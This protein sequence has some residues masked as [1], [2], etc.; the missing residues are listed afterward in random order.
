[1]RVKI[2]FVG[3]LLACL[4]VC[5]SCRQKQASVEE[6]DGSMWQIDLSK[7]K[8]SLRD[9]VEKI[10]F[11]P[12]EMT[13]RSVLFGADKMVLKNGLM[14]VGDFRSGK[15][16]AFDGDGKVEFVVDRKGSGP[17]EYLE[18]KSFAVDDR[19]IYAIDNYQHHLNLFDCRTGE[20]QSTKDMPLV[21]WDVEVLPDKNL[22]FAYI[23]FKEGAP[24]MPQARFKIHITDS[25]LNVE[26]QMFAY[27]ESDYECMG[28][29]TYFVPVTQGVVFSSMASDE[30]YEFCG[31]DSV[32]QM[33]LDFAHKIPA[34]HRKDLE[35]IQQRGYSYLVNTPL[36]CKQY[37]FFSSP[38][39]GM[40]L[41]YV[42]NMQTRQLYTNDLEDAYKG[43]LTP[44]VVDGGRVIAYFDNY[45][46][47]QD[48]VQAGFERAPRAVEEHL[49]AEKPVL[50][51]YT[52]K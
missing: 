46:Y 33:T 41:D 32:R 29:K 13:D 10:D 45:L 7:A 12:L 40:I 19:H 23:P 48:L 20:Y 35:E 52:L 49:K 47:Y 24:N 27:E 28:K 30:V 31:K 2:V 34:A 8:A 21:A 3:M 18:I 4:G 36:F 1:M 14:Y 16:V 25:L 50:V 44:Q 43:L 37:M 15:V 6:A 17:G 38:K 11:V 9:M 39:D 22:I 42:Y 51:L 26:K 5:A